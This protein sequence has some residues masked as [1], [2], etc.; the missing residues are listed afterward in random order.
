VQVLTAGTRIEQDQENKPMQV[1]VVTLVVNPEQAEH[2]ALASTEGK[3]QLALRNPL[4]QGSPQTPGIKTAALV[5]GVRAA[6]RQYASAP[7]A[8]KPGQAVTMT[9]APVAVVP[10]VEIIRGD[11]RSTEVIK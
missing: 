9:P 2:L 3:I 8:S 10:T 11:K 5:G 6:P 4:D 1:T 7:R